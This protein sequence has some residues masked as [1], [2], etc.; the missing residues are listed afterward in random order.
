MPKGEWKFLV[1]Y[2]DAFVD[3]KYPNT[4]LASTRNLPTRRR[5]GKCHNVEGLNAYFWGCSENEINSQRIRCIKSPRNRCGSMILFWNLEKLI[6]LR[7]KNWE[8]VFK[9]SYD[10]SKGIY[11]F[12]LTDEDNVS[13]ETAYWLIFDCQFLRAK[14]RPKSN[15]QSNEVVNHN[16]ELLATC[17]KI[18]Q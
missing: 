16:K 4:S 10:R 18:Q 17:R 11:P 15:D 5:N 8:T 12:F 1:S 9:P 7:I 13:H 3:Q 6:C 2:L 14:S